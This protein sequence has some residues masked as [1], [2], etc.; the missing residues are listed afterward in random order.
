MAYEM[1]SSPHQVLSTNFGPH[2]T[3]RAR[4]VS[5]VLYYI[6]YVDKEQLGEKNRAGQERVKNKVGTGM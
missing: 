3:Q 6:Q 5:A 2:P 4:I 1:Q